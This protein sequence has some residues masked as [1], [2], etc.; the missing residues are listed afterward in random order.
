MVELVHPLFVSISNGKV[1]KTPFIDKT[2]VN[3]LDMVQQCF[4]HYI[5]ITP[6]DRV[7]T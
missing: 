3:T 7:E 1:S 6:E 4:S 5:Y 2:V